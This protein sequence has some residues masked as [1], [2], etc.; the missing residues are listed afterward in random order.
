MGQPLTY[1]LSIQNNGPANASGVTLTDELPAGMSFNS[2]TPSQG[3][4]T[5][6][7]AVPFPQLAV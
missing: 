5:E 3:N 4:C 6:T 1:T 7:N 2:A